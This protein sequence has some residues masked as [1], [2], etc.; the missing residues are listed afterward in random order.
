MDAKGF[1]DA[2]EFWD[3]R[4]APD[5]YIFGVE[6]NAFLLQHQSHFRAGMRVLDLA[7]G[8]GRNSVWLASLGCAVTGIDLSPRALDKAR[9]LAR[10]R[11]VAPEF[12][13]ADVRSVAWAESDY[14]A[15]LTIFVQFAAPEGR[16][17]VFHG[18]Q[19]TL[20]PNGLLFL[21]GFTPAQLA[22]T[23]GGPKQLSH[24][25]TSA[26]LR[27]LTQGM[28]ILHLREHENVLQEGS[29]HVGRAALID[30]I[31]RKLS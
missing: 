8:E 7:C 20:K 14:D 9:Q 22:F 28:E 27:E 19:R 13:E 3:K 10:A 2:R 31:A 1:D 18:I 6:P 23:S 30:L 16:E 25:Y 26:L 5:E 17:R 15:V 29:K 4:Y 12:I 24:L 11:H 21:Q